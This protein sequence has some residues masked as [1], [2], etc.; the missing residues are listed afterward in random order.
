MRRWR[1]NV[2]VGE[3]ILRTDNEVEEEEAQK[4]Q[5]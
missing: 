5:R 4:E 2:M 3:V 1:K